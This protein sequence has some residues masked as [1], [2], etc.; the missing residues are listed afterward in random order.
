V[1]VDFCVL[2]FSKKK[3][4][5][6]F[7]QNAFFFPLFLGE[8]KVKLFHTTLFGAHAA[9]ATNINNGILKRRENP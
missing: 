4:P 7:H 3:N 2:V 6:F 5:K 1:S 8:T 9:S